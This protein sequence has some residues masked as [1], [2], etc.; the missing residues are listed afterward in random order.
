MVANLENVSGRV[1]IENRDLHGKDPHSVPHV[2]PLSDKSTTDVRTSIT[3]NS[4]Q[5]TRPEKIEKVER[6]EKIERV[7]RDGKAGV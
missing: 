1:K 3:D 5:D 7:E 4:G 6:P 2:Q